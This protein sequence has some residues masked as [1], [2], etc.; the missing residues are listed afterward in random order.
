M[1]S[2]HVHALCYIT[3]AARKKKYIEFKLSIIYLPSLQGLWS[4]T[5]LV[6][7]W[8]ERESDA[9]L[10][11]SYTLTLHHLYFCWIPNRSFELKRPISAQTPRQSRERSANRKRERTL[12][13]RGERWDK[14]KL[15]RF[16]S[17]I[18]QQ[19]AVMLLQCQPFERKCSVKVLH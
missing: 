15:L 14:E 12:E 3:W 8:W 18:S 1:L 10:I 17:H 9:R 2:I 7:V 6:C 16:E 5:H 4:H 11:L 19:S 13:G